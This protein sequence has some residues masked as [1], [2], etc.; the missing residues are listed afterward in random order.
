MISTVTFFY[1]SLYLVLYFH[2]QRSDTVPWPS[3]PNMIAASLLLLGAVGV[4]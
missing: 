4:C 3:L 1:T 2:P